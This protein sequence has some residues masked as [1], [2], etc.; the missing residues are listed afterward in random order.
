M[1]A[2]PFP[3]DEKNSISVSTRQKSKFEPY[4]RTQ[5]KFTTADRIMQV[6]FDIKKD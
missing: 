4:A 3:H 1:T 6:L 2:F 5:K